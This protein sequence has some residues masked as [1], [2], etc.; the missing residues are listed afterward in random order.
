MRVA[1]G[2]VGCASTPVLAS[3]GSRFSFCT[4][5]I[6][7][8]WPTVE[9]WSEWL[10][11]LGFAIRFDVEYVTPAVAKIREFRDAQR[12]VLN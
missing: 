1:A 10:G 3:D 7:L 6:M 2:A 9:Y 8:T 12:K 4:G 11:W 5:E